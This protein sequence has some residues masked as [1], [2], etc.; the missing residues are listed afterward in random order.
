MPV[1]QYF[2]W[3]LRTGVNPP[4]YKIKVTYNTTVNKESS[5]S[6]RQPA[7]CCRLSVTTSHNIAIAIAPHIES[8]LHIHSVLG[9]ISHHNTGA[10]R[11]KFWD[12]AAISTVF[13]YN[14]NTF[15][16]DLLSW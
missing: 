15:I 10:M 12:T 14:Y 13:I 6:V 2:C 8:H 3:S 7:M 9:Y 16:P 1:I 11:P 4:A 5:R